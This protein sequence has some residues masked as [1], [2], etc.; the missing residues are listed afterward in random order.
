MLLAGKVLLLYLQAHFGV[1]NFYFKGSGKT[2][3][4][5]LLTAR[6]A[7]VSCPPLRVQNSL[8]RVEEKQDLRWT[9]QTMVVRTIFQKVSQM[10]I[11]YLLVMHVCSKGWRECLSHIC[12]VGERFRRY[13][14]RKAWEMPSKRKPAQI[15]RLGRKLDRLT[16]LRTNLN[17]MLAETLCSCHLC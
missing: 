4:T 2:S 6:G 12:D 7:Q 15:S 9:K 3:P 14:W 5:S 10:L 1:W 13:R 8:P 17:D 16:V 11:H